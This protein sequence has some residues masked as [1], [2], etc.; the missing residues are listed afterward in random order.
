MSHC[1][2]E[3][4]LRPAP[5]RGLGPTLCSV[6]RNGRAEAKLTASLLTALFSPDAGTAN[7]NV[8][9]WPTHLHPSPP[10]HTCVLC[11]HCPPPPGVCYP[12]QGW[13][14]ILTPRSGPW[15]SPSTPTR[16]VPASL[17]FWGAG[18]AWWS[19]LRAGPTRLHLPITTDPGGQQ[20]TQVTGNHPQ[21]PRCC[22][23][24]PASAQP[25]LL[26]T[27][28]KCSEVSVLACS[29]SQQTNKTSA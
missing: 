13:P 29:R 7:T 6:T 1:Q 8:H 2:E 20:V 9:P 18:L 15:C 16:Q 19:G 14:H 24:G 25:W 5:T 22:A 4:S 28:G 10:L 27:F 17:H 3:S 11:S 26:Q 12:P 23:P 21:R